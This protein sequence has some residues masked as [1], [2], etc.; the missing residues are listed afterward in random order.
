VSDTAEDRL[1]RLGKSVA[2]LKGDVQRLSGDMLVYSEQ[3]ERTENA[4][5]VLA[6]AIGLLGF[7][8]VV[9]RG[10]YE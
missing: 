5:M 7:F 10:H 1:I 8:L 4:L 9:A 2:E 6:G 3:R